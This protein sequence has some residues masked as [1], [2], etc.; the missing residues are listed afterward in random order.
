MQVLHVTH[1][2]VDGLLVDLA[3]QHLEVD[4]QL[5]LVEG[6]AEIEL[7]EQPLV[8]GGSEVTLVGQFIYHFSI[9]HFLIYERHDFLNLIAV[10]VPEDALVVDRE[11]L[12]EHAVGVLLLLLEGQIC[13]QTHLVA[14]RRSVVELLHHS[15]GQRLLEDSKLIHITLETFATEI[16]RAADG[17]EL[18]G[19]YGVGQLAIHKHGCRVVRAAECEGE[20]V[21]LAVGV[22]AGRPLVS[23]G[24]QHEFAVLYSQQGTLDDAVGVCP[25]GAEQ[26]CVGGFGLEP[27][28]QC[29]VVV[30]GAPE[31][32]GSEL[33]MLVFE[34]E[35]YALLQ[36]PGRVAQV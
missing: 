23:T 34:L 17:R 29:L 21:P 1:G 20:V 4:E 18:H 19:S 32:I 16:H 30:L 11:Y 13:H 9:Y 3:V 25:R 24:V 22:L 35:R 8:A 28:H 33:Y 12:L 31:Q 15:C 26:R 10:R 6:P 27:E 14:Y 2:D 7:T 5:L 36:F